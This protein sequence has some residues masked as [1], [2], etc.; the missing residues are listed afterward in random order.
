M[1][2][3]CAGSERLF[4]ILRIGPRFKNDV[5]WAV[6]LYLASRTIKVLL[7]SSGSFAYAPSSAK[8][9]GDSENMTKSFESWPA[10]CSNRNRSSYPRRVCHS[11]YSSG[12]LKAEARA[13]P[14]SC[15]RLQKASRREAAGSLMSAIGPPKTKTRPRPDLRRVD[16]GFTKSEKIAIGVV[17]VNP[18]LP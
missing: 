3:A 9:P 8:E 11:G 15:A 2:V 4:S 6:D 12:V 18:Q 10:S 17:V 16:S 7:E 1:Q 5:W 13:P 14:S